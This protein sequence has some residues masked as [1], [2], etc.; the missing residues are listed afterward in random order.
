MDVRISYGIEI[1]KVPERVNELI[2]EID[3]GE[4][5][6]AVDLVCQLLALSN[7]EMAEKLIEQARIKM[8]EIDRILNDSQMILKGY[9]N[10]KAQEEQPPPPPEVNDVS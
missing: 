4:I 8:G 9:V 6:Q 10:T 5:G 7:V 2:S 3:I 1:E